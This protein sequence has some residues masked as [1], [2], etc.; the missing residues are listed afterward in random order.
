[1]A[2]YTKSG[3]YGETNIFRK[4]GLKPVRLSKSSPKIRAIGSVDEANTFIGIVIS[5]SSDNK[6]NRSL[7]EIQKD[8]FSIGASLA[9][10]P[11]IYLDKRVSILEKEIDALEVTLPVLKNFILPGG[12]TVAATLSYARALVRRAEREVVEL[13][14]KQKLNTKILVY[15]NRLSDYLFILSRKENFDSRVKEIV[16]KR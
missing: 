14:K 7:E 1:M 11:T 5:T 4:Q 10:A 16:W 13:S 8:L 6:L 9:G 3:D 12:N 2:V 15:L